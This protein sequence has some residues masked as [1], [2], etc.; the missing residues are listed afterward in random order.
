MKDG[1]II[2]SIT[3]LVDCLQDTK[4][5]LLSTTKIMQIN[6]N[7]EL[8]FENNPEEFIEIFSQQYSDTKQKTICSIN[9]LPHS[10]FPYTEIAHLHGSCEGKLFRLKGHV[11]SATDPMSETKYYYDCPACRKKYFDKK[12]IKLCPFCKTRYDKSDIKLR[13][14]TYRELVFQE[15]FDFVDGKSKR[16]QEVIEMRLYLPERAE[17][18]LI[19]YDDLLGQELDVLG[20]LRL[21]NRGEVR[22]HYLEI[23]GI[24]PIHQR[25]L[26]EN[27]INKVRKFIADNRDNIITLLTKHICEKQG[28]YGNQKINEAILC[29]CNGLHPISPQL[30]GKNKQMV[31]IIFS[32]AGKGK[33]QT[34][35]KFLPYFERSAYITANVSGAGL[36][37]G[38]E[39]NIAGNWSYNMGRLPFSNNSFVILDEIDNMHD[40]PKQKLLTILSEG[41]IQVTKIKT[42]EMNIH[43][44]FLIL[45]NPKESFF[46]PYS[47]YFRQI[48][49]SRPFMDRADF[50]IIMKDA[51]D[52]DDDA[53]LQAFS[54]TIIG[55]KEHTF[56]LD[57]EFVKDILHYTKYYKD[58]PKITEESG[59]KIGSYWIDA[60]KAERAMSE[61]DKQNYKPIGAR[62]SD[63][64]KKLSMC[65]ARLR[66]K[67]FVDVEDVE[68]AYMLLQKASYD[69]LRQKFGTEEL[70]VVSEKVT[71]KKKSPSNERELGEWL[72]TELENKEDKSIDF[73]E[74]LQIVVTD[75]KLSER[76]LDKVIIR[77]KEKEGM[78]FEPR[79]G[80]IKLL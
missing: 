46:D 78:I 56:D 14:K 55:I 23:V 3:K 8:F 16:Q 13:T 24:S 58:N 51:F 11:N 43:I 71:G 52:I 19:S 60:K 36:V 5:I 27:R 7:L 4:K 47:E 45:G 80:L 39:K 41:L 35:K 18:H 50:L 29:V 49:L 73:Q 17:Y 34:A 9:I 1:E 30:K 2:Q 32:D 77:L 10:T 12:E 28:I 6:P 33:T 48:D 65:V 79:A 40:D 44:N 67:D 76:M 20:I 66:D 64:L 54:D 62:V 42:F 37:G 59:K 68:Y 57:D 22:Y 75:M 38:A 31:A 15:K 21:R 69:T 61:S 53:D 70:A 63:T 72:L 25:R 74:L 26:T